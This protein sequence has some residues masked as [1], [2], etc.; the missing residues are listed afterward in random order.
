M[1]VAVVYNRESKS[2]INLFGQPNKEKYG[3]KA[4]DRILDALKKAGR[5]AIA[6]EGDKGLIENLEKFMPRTLKGE[7]PG[8]VFNL[9]YGIQGQARYTHVPGILE[10]VGVPY[11]GS[12]PLAHSLCLDKVVTKMILRQ[13]GLPTPDFAVLQGPGFEMPEL[14]YPLIVKPK[15]EAV[16]FGIRIVNNDQEM[17]EAADVIFREYSQPVLVEQYIE[18]KEVN[19]GL[20]GNSPPEAMVPVELRFEGEGPNIYTYEDKTRKSGREIRLVCPPD[21]N[22]EIVAKAQELASNAFSALGCYDCARVDM[23]LDNEGN[24]FILEIN[25]LPSL[26]EH[27]SYVEAASHM[28]M[29]FPALVNRL[30]DVASTR[31]FG[32]P[33]P[34]PFNTKGT[35]PHELVFNYLTGRRDLMEER[36]ESWT[37]IT[38][39]TSDALSQQMVTA[40]LDKFF[41]QMGM[42]PSDEF[43]DGRSVR[44]WETKK[45]FENGVLLAL[46]TDVPLNP[47]LYKQ[48]FRKTPEWIYG[49]GVGMSRAPLVTME[50]A[51]R[52]LRAHRLLRKIPLGVICYSDEGLDCRYSSPVISQAMARASHVIVLRPGNPPDSMVI[53]RRGQRNYKLLVEG[54]PRRVGQVLK[55][56]DPLTWFFSKMEKLSALSSKKER[57]SVSAVDV[58]TQSTPML[59]PDK[60]T[61]SFLVT[62]PEIKTANELEVKIRDI[63]GK[64][65]L[66]WDLTL[67]SDRPPMMKTRKSQQFIKTMEKVSANWEIPLGQES[68]LWPSVA[69]LAPRSVSVVCGAAPVARD[70]YTTQEAVHRTS[71]VQRT[72]LLAQILAEQIK[73]A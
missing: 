39:R 44:L 61:A 19:V 50:F 68:S 4:I 40:E 3:K 2:V 35:D 47:A 22:P 64:K 55:Q 67:V 57:I 25:S 69:G 42:K 63:L 20:L 31:Y 16:S 58:A 51:L 45:G 5:Q 32:T 53:Q 38:S 11:V 23:R 24:L 8:M 15:N 26:G 18:G 13:H 52:S 46:H 49:E 41:S 9:S 73:S 65:S 54:K 59:T 37:R 30:I 14:E 29:D 33:A 6:L 56:P 34:P 7:R 10:M 66:R 71:L 21:L 72:L 60:V 62:Y 36:L 12:G 70:L 1:K 27:G 43:G 28:G 17:R 48:P